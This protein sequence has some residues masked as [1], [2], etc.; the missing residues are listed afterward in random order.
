MEPIY[1]FG[2]IYSQSYFVFIQMGWQWKLHNEA[3]YSFI[4]ILLLD[5]F[6]GIALDSIY[7]TIWPEGASIV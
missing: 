3:V 5:L 1:I 4:M 6:L 2:R 7:F